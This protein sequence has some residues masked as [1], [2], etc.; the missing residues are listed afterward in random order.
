M[1]TYFQPASSVS[2][3]GMYVMGLF[4]GLQVLVCDKKYYVCGMYVVDTK[5]R[6]A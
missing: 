6:G 3:Y 2:H 1:T 5:T 4:C